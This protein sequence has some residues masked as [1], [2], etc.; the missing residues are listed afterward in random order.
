MNIPGEQFDILHDIARTADPLQCFPGP[1]N[2]DNIKPSDFGPEH[3]YEL[4]DHGDTV[5]FFPISEAGLQWCYKVLPEDTPRW[6]SKGFVI[7]A[8]YIDLLCRA[9]REN[10][11]MSED[12]YEFAMQEMNEQRR[13]WE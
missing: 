12:E 6:G 9:A 4:L 11:L 7:E 13:M 2:W 3:D 1:N 8:E 5:V 10:N